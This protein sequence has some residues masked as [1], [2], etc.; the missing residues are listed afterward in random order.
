MSKNVLYVVCCYDEDKTYNVKPK[1]IFKE[2]HEF[3]DYEV[4]DSIIN[5]TLPRLKI[6]C[7]YY[8]VELRVIKKIPSEIQ[9][10]CDKITAL[11]TKEYKD[12]N[13]IKGFNLKVQ[14]A[15]YWF[16][17]FYILIE[18]CKSKYQKFLYLDGDA[19][20]NEYKDVFSLLDNGLYV[21]TK[22][23]T[24][25]CPQYRYNKKYLD[26][27]IDSFIC[28]N[29]F[30]GTNHIKESMSKIV[31]YDILS[32]L[33]KEPKLFLNDEV[34]LTYLFKEYNMLRELKDETLG[35]KFSAGSERIYQYV[36]KSRKLWE[37]LN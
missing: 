5:T 35:L 24:T 4:R 9:I 1:N 20:V 6:W 25:T 32:N 15:K 16:I 17:K 26:N 21:K 11:Y 18:F 22:P 23:A 27:T 30:G 19:F 7:E 8:N 10:L 33:L 37:I 3:Y 31:T 29:I 2:E 12:T 28:G 34:I 13:L 36:L 14:K